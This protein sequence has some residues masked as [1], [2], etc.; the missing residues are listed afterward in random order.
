MA[1]PR[2]K[3]YGFGANRPVWLV[4]RGIHGFDGP[5]AISKSFQG[6]IAHYV[7]SKLEFHFIPPPQVS[8]AG[9]P[10]TSWYEYDTAY[11]ERYMSL[12]SLNPEGYEG[13][14]VINNVKQLPDE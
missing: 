7:V 8:I 5:F 9:A 4:L 14:S 2:D 13:G 3:L 12:P 1:L 11:T 6:T 10:V